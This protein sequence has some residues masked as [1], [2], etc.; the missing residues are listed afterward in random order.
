MS[1]RDQT[2]H[3]AS[4]ATGTR[5]SSPPNRSGGRDV[6]QTEISAPGPGEGRAWSPGVA[7]S[8]KAGCVKDFPARL[9]FGQGAGN[10]RALHTERIGC[11]QPGRS[12][13]R[14][15]RGYAEAPPV[16]WLQS[17]CAPAGTLRGRAGERDTPRVA[18]D[19]GPARATDLP[20]F[21]DFWV[22]RED[23]SGRLPRSRALQA[24]RAERN[25]SCA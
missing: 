21:F 20:R 11:G 10:I 12:R 9:I 15:S 16:A 17:D 22:T 1:V 18:A 5:K 13:P 23:G 7:I 14:P 25:R 6:L 8:R 4:I 3:V 24:S 2:L 19:P